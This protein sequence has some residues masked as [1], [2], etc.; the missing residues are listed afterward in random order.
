MN[1]KPILFLFTAMFVLSACSINPATGERQFTALMSPSQEVKVGAQEHQKIIAQFGLYK[2]AAL[3]EYVSRV[4]EA[5]TQKTE[6]PDV[7][8][9]FFV[10]DSPMVNA[11]ALPGGYIYVT[12]GLL[13]LAGNEAE[14]AAVLA[15]ETGHIT[16]RHSAERYSHGVVSSLGGTLLG[17]IVSA[18]GVGQAA[19]IGSDLYIKSYSRSQE[20][21]AD[22]LGLRYLAH[23]E[24]DPAAMV[25]FLERLQ[26]NGALERRKSGQ[27]G[28]AEASY[29]S[30]H[31]A[32]GERVQKTSLEAQG[33]PA[34]SK[35][36]RDVYLQMIDGLTYG[37]SAAHGF[38]RG[39]KFYHPVLGF[40]FESPEGYRLIN[41]PT[42]VVMT[43]RDGSLIL[44]DMV[45]NP[46]SVDASNYLTKIWMKDRKLSGLERITVN[47]AESATASF[48]G[49]VN[50]QMMTIRLIAVPY[51]N[52]FARF[53][54]GI[55]PGTQGSTI[56]K[57]KEA[58]YSFRSLT[59]AEKSALKPLR[60]SIVQAKAGDT[61][62]SLAKRQ[63]L[64]DFQ[65]E[66]FQVLN[67]LLA[68]SGVQAGSFY[69]IITRE[70]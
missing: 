57:L 2:D 21:E 31:P 51:G 22:S 32:T 38:V 42:E 30:T 37:D 65:T 70:K 55:P 28:S 13:A 6:R 58:T 29:F 5:V 7:R 40:V 10:L 26:A 46:S 11:F 25:R 20:N 59:D 44:F 48:Q 34:H 47:G 33:Y 54:I 69:K 63:A 49:K 4:G 36:N 23:A 35:T 41:R 62:R 67:G 27:G 9:Q 15:H 61:A 64:E 17:A 24:Y 14:M 1:C 8:Y 56:E 12:R 66:T 19:N 60:L 39:N 18:P 50:G 68:G 45:S 53:Q 3:S 52:S 16:A 43:A